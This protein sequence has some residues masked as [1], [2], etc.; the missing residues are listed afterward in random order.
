MYQLNEIQQKVFNDR[1]A[2]KDIEGNAVEKNIEDMW[3]RIADNIASIENDKDV[4]SKEFYNILYDFKFVPG[5]RILSGA[6]NDKVT[7]FNCY[8]LPSPE[9]SRQGIMRN[10]TDMV[11]IMSR[12]GGVGV[13]LSTLRPKGAYVKGVNGYSSGVTSWGELYS[14]ATGSVCQGGSRRGALLLG[15]RV[16]HPDIEEFITIKRDFNKLNNANLSVLITD[17]FMEAVKNNSN[18]ELK[19]NEKIYKTIKANYLW[20]LICE[21]AWN[22][23]EPGIIFIDRYNQMSNSWYCEEIICCNP[24]GEQGLPAWGVCNL[25]SINLNKFI[26]DDCKIDYDNLN[27][28]IKI[29]V[30]FLDNVIDKTPYFFEQNERI[31]KNSRRIGLGTLGLADMLIKQKIRYGSQEAIKVCNELYEFIAIESYKVSIDLAKEKGIFLNYNFD[32]FFIENKNSLAYKIYNLLSKEYQENAKKYGIR[33]MTILTQAPTG[34]TG[35]LANTSS[36]T[37]PNFAFE[38]KRKDRL[39]EHF[40]K[41]PLYENWIKTIKELPKYFVTAQE[42]TPEEH[43]TMQ[44]TIQK[45]VDSSISKTIN[46]PK[47]HSVKEVKKIYMLSYDLG[48]KGITYYRDGSRN[49]Q[50]LTNINSDNYIYEGDIPRGFVIETPD[51]SHGKRRKIYTGCG[52]LYV[53][54]FYDEVTGEILETFLS[55]GSTGGCE[56]F[57]QFSSRLMSRLLRIGDTTEGIADQAFSVGA[58]PSWM[59][60]KG[61]GLKLSK[62][63]NCPS[64]IAYTL[65]DIQNEIKDELGLEELPK[66]NKDAKIVYLENKEEGAKCPECNTELRFIEGCNSCPNCGYSKCN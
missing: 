47:T 36:S 12:G 48:N 49:E 35:L 50:V 25:G 2:L 1:Y 7:F 56:R 3:K 28:T 6:G 26:T 22:S 30:R 20:N 59:Y 34:S 17:K 5:G 41:H 32:K 4:W 9:D 27:K 46:A 62:G 33:N 54:A 52:T 19:F 51:D 40:I 14:Q 29:A 64:A 13:N 11:E 44:A 42:L 8:V 24:C 65:I 39:G 57:M 58:C 63:K 37:E 16:D 15:L 43:V 45:W 55:K 31:Q 38:I 18:W 61:K 66:F 23:G 10:I 21:S 53:K 60:A